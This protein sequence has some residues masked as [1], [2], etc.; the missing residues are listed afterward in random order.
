[1]YFIGLLSFLYFDSDLENKIYY[2]KSAVELL[3]LTSD[4]FCFPHEPNSSSLVKTCF[5]IS[6]NGV[7]CKFAMQVFTEGTY[8]S[9]THYLLPSELWI[10]QNHLIQWQVLLDFTAYCY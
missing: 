5:S 4:Y 6:E 9:V 8:F 1:M 2:T 3:K 10:Y 7:L